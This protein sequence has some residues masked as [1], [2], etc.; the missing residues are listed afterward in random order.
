MDKPTINMTNWTLSYERFE[1]YFYLQGLADE[2]PKLGS[3][4]MITHTSEVLDSILN[5]DILIC[6]THNSIYACPLKYMEYPSN[7]LDTHKIKESKDNI[8]YKIL[9]AENNIHA[10]NKL[11]SFE[12]HIKELMEQG[13]EELKEKEE[14]NNNRLMQEASKYKNSLYIE[15]SSI[16]QGSTGAY[17]IEDKTGIIVP[18]LHVGTFQDS[19]LYTVPGVVDF[20][21]FPE[22]GG[23][24]V[25]SWSE[26]LENVI[27]KNMKNSPI[28]I[29]KDATISSK[30]TYVL[31]KSKYT[32]GLVSPDCVTGQSVLKLG[33]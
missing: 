29:Y 7:S 31:D 30:E 10:D 5:D 24:R 9:V 27:I 12:Q 14:C 8:L 22:W 16:S 18:D 33:D 2:H 32:C 4:V 19:V 3:N 23:I 6:E 26:N 17:N 21:Y 13:K 28:E 11:N 25:Y 15:L 20:R 1:K